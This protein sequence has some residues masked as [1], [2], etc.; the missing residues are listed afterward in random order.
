MLIEMS[1]Q[2]AGSATPPIEAIIFDVDGVLVYS[3]TFGKQLQRL[4][5]DASA[6]Q[7]FWHGPFVECSLGRADLKQVMG[8]FIEAWGYPGTVEEC[9]AAWFAADSNL[10]HALLADVARLRAGGVRCHVASTQERHRAR[11]LQTTL[12]LGSRFDRF[13]F[14]CQVGAKKPDPKFYE[15]VTRELGSPPA[16][17]LFFDDQPANVDAARAAGWRAELYAMGTPLLPA[18]ARHGL[19]PR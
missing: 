1:A 8:S 11:Y 17:L 19:A 15:H 18:L 3:G 16:A 5:V 2:A 7:E 9:L 10:N 4:G 6:L 12:G 14:S 13:F